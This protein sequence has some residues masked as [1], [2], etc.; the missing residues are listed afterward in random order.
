MDIYRAKLDS[1]GALTNIANA[2]ET[3]DIV[4]SVESTSGTQPAGG[5]TTPLN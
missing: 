3:F 4:E 2:P 1:N 5:L